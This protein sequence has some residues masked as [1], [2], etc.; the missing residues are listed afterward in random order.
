M[1]ECII[2]YDSLSRHNDPVFVTKRT[3]KSI[4][5]AKEEREKSND[6]DRISIPSIKNLNLRPQERVQKR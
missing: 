2:H 6:R 5:L 3:S 4:L 1:N